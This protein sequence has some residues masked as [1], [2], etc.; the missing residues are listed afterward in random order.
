MVKKR[1]DKSG[2]KLASV[3][4]Y[5]G[6]YLDSGRAIF[7]SHNWP[8]RDLFIVCI[9]AIHR[10]II[11]VS[12]WVS[13]RLAHTHVPPTFTPHTKGRARCA[14]EKKY[15]WGRR[16]GTF[17]YPFV[18]GVNVG[19]TRVCVWASLGLTHT[20]YLNNMSVYRIYTQWINLGMANCGWKIWF[21]C[22]CFAQNMILCQI[23]LKMHFSEKAFL[24]PISNSLQKVTSN[25]LVDS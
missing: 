22:P 1:Y 7:F 10:H 5:F 14:R 21:W 12:V 25:A 11:Q 20:L 15:R 9:Y 2:L 18:C 23:L 4:W 16:R 8:C 13:P 19:G 3:V 6:P 24:S 17:V